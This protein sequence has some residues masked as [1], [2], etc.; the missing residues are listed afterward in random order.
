MWGVLVSRIAKNII[1]LDKEIKCS[2]EN[3]IF[4]AKGKLG[5]MQLNVKSN[6]DIKILD[7]EVSV[8]PKFQELRQYVWDQ[9]RSEIEE[10]NV[11]KE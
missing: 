9:V 4:F 1:K 3:G 6:F 8:L 11:W 7:N 5:E 2:F 10:K